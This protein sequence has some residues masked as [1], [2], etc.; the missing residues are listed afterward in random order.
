MTSLVPPPK[1]NGNEVI[2]L[3]TGRYGVL[4]EKPHWSDEHKMW[5]YPYLYGWTSEGYAPEH[6][7]KVISPKEIDR[8]YGF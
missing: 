3:T 1:F 2:E 8:M 7:I 6:I 5:L 4:W